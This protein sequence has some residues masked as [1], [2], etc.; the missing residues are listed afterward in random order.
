MM[1]ASCERKDLAILAA[2]YISSKEKEN[3]EGHSVIPNLR[4]WKLRRQFVSGTVPVPKCLR[5]LKHKLTLCIQMRSS[6][7]YV[8]YLY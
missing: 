8:P 6:I 3:V 7:A 5:V 2:K 1:S 4:N